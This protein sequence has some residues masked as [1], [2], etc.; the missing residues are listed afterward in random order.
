MVFI[1]NLVLE[2]FALFFSAVLLLYII[3]TSYF[4]FS[5]AK[6]EFEGVKEGMIPIFIL[7]I[8]MFVNALAEELK[9]TLPGSYNILFYDPF[10][11]FGILLISLSITI[12]F[13]KKI[14]YIGF[15][16]MLFGIIVILYGI[17]GY[18]LGM[19]KSPQMLLG[20]YSLFGLAGIF[21]Y[22]ATLVY[23]FH[24]QSRFYLFAFALFIL[25]LA[26]AGLAALTLGIVSLPAH[27]AS[28]P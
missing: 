6:K 19:T 14:N 16:A 24:S 28:A 5:K 3:I 27:L 18:N 4:R 12:F 7:G 11:M 13:G 15:L 23:D 25:F 20:L 17:Y 10:M 22:P 21:A 2:L 26:L 8:F 1:D 9:W